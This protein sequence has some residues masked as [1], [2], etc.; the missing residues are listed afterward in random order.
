MSVSENVH[1]KVYATNENSTVTA[2]ATADGVYIDTHATIAYTQKKK[3]TLY[4]SWNK[5]WGETPTDAGNYYYLVWPIKTYV[6]KNTSCYSF[7]LNDTCTDM[8]SSVIG[9]RFSGQS[10][11]SDI[12]SI[13]NVKTYGDRYDYVLT[14]YSKADADAI[15]KDAGRFYIHNDI[16]AIVSPSDHV[17]IDTNATSSYD[18][19]YESPVYI[20]G[21]GDFW[22]EKYGI[23]G[24]YN[25]VESSE[26]ISNYVL[27]EFEEGDIDTLPNLKYRVIGDGRPSAYTIEDGGT[28]EVEDAIN[29]M[30]WKKK[31]DYNITDDGIAIEGTAL[32]D[33]DYDVSKAELKTLIKEAVFDETTYEF[34]TSK[35]DVG[36]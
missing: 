32:N 24:E 5:A 29:D 23:Y 35:K 1:A 27:G 12:N 7:T 10:S 9:Y 19:F 31:V 22:A 8:K 4:R 33:N 15:S 17:D 36:I 28:G 26:D 6:N 25:K 13:D 34:K 14:R 2:D 20:Y 18:W 11:F 3:P 16:E 21:K 30:F